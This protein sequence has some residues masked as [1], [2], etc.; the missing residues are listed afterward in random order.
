MRAGFTNDGSIAYQLTP[1]QA[2]CVCIWILP[3]SPD[4]ICIHIYDSKDFAAVWDC[5]TPNVFSLLQ[6]SGPP[7]SYPYFF[8]GL[9]SLVQLTWLKQQCQVDIALIHHLIFICDLKFH[10]GDVH[11]S[12]VFGVVPNLPSSIRVNGFPDWA[13]TIT[14]HMDW[15]SRRWLFGTHVNSICSF[16]FVRFCSN[17]T[18]YQGF[19]LLRIAWREKHQVW[20]V[21]THECSPGPPIG[22]P[23]TIETSL[24]CILLLASLNVHFDKRMIC[25]LSAI[26]KSTSGPKPQRKA[27]HLK[28]TSLL[29]DF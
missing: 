11:G 10:F 7:T 21:R 18:F 3:P 5:I 13:F 8:L 25:F 12:C 19:Q 4:Q 20:S 28:D 1:W 24:I 29:C 17:I 23:D 2:W 9:A 16:S 26:V 27:Y 22:P 6:V 14:R 15:S